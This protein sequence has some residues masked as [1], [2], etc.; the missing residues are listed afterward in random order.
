MAASRLRILTFTTLFPNP[1]EPGR[2]SFVRDRVAAMAALA[3]ITVV[4]PVNVGRRPEL[5]ALPASRRDNAGFTVH[6]PRFAVFPRVLKGLDGAM[7]YHETRAQLGGLL[8]S[9][10]ADLVDSHYAYPD[11]AAARHIA[12]LAGKPFALTVRGSDLEVLALDRA[13]RGPIMATL[14]AADSVIAVSN[15]LRLRAIEFGAAP[16]RVS[17]IPNGVDAGRF[18]PS[19]RS[20]ARR[21]LGL[22]ED[23]RLV[24]VVGRLDPVKGLDLLVQAAAL[25]RDAEKDPVRFRLLGEGPMRSTLERSIRDASLQERV[26]LHGAVPAESLGSWYAAADVVCLLSR[27]E[28][29]PNVIVEALACGRPVVATSVGGI[30]ELIVPSENGILLSSREPVV[31]AAAI[32]AAL[33]RAWDPA[34]I[35]R[36]ERSRSWD[37]VARAHLDVYQRVVTSP[38]RSQGSSATPREASA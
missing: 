8:R 15:S 27:S 28:G 29:C 12:A 3:D 21:A 6:H 32:E 33:G 18:H 1:G 13:R 31:A 4:A 24:L 38:P 26:L 36:P 9:V 10:D 34:A 17:L 22:P 14:R 37:D 23:E 2:G 16:E 11:G 20:A 35:A 5:L 7:L 30:P 19:D 25:V